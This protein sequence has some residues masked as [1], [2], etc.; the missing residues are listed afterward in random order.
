MIDKTRE[1]GIKIRV[2]RDETGS[3]P[4]MER[5]E[6]IE[7]NLQYLVGD[8]ERAT[9][10]M[11]IKKVKSLSMLGNEGKLGCWPIFKYPIG[12]VF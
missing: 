4:A 8:E 7:A 9:L 12:Q 11:V 6:H 1:E 5:L 10:Q 2:W 3:F